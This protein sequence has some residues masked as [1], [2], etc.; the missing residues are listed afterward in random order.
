M[1]DG[2]LNMNATLQS[3][4]VGQGALGS[5]GGANIPLMMAGAKMM[6]SKSP[7]ALG[8]V[9]EGLEGYAGSL[10]DQRKRVYEDEVNKQALF[11]SAIDNLKL[12]QVE[13]MQRAALGLPPLPPLAQG[14]A[15]GGPVGPSAPVGYG[16]AETAATGPLA[17][18]GG[19]GMVPGKA[20][21]L[22]SV[23]GVSTLERL[24]GDQLLDKARQ[25]EYMGNKTVS[26]KLASAATAG[27]IKG[28]ET[29]AGMGLTL[30][31]HDSAGNPLYTQSP[32]FLLGKEGESYSTERGKAAGGVGADMYA[33][34]AE[35][36]R[37]VAENEAAK[38]GG[39]KGAEFPYE[40]GLKRVEG[41][42]TRTTGTQRSNQ[43]TY[44]EFDPVTNRMVR[45][46][47]GGGPLGVGGQAAPPATGAAPPA[48]PSTTETET[49]KVS[50]QKETE[51]AQQLL[52][53]AQ[54]LDAGALNNIEKLGDIFRRFE[55]GKWSPA[56]GEVGA[57]ARALG[58]PGLEKLIGMDKAAIESL[59]KEA[60]GQ[61]FGIVREAT[62]RPAVQ[63]FIM[64]AKQFASGDM[65]PEA[66][67]DI[68][69]KTIGRMRFEKDL[70]AEFRKERAKNPTV[71][72]SDVQA[73]FTKKANVDNYI[74]DA[75]VK[76]GPFKGEKPDMLP[77][78]SQA[79]GRFILE[80]KDTQGRDIVFNITSRKWELKK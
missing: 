71:R 68:L 73:E 34:R 65:Q 54:N 7:F 79:T 26:E 70:A 25:A 63:E 6:T 59:D 46:V 74:K 43:E 78:I 2:P 24:T 20:G 19:G 10:L 57:A 60:M 49:A 39:K 36:N 35:F 21:G 31:G 29:A 64:A 8:A 16:T 9:G 50:A 72:L 37:A 75:W 28:H 18:A 61:V 58:L 38:A 67:H 51:N 15:S 22:A 77:P 76:M 48:A 11:K 44:E 30:Q 27:I 40:A 80:T 23:G 5:M 56:K 14:A 1:A 3:L 32:T 42:E 52:D 66:A 12:Y 33:G 55:S 62:P 41:E 53:Y 45:K 17:A 13:N 4:G 69:A 47:R